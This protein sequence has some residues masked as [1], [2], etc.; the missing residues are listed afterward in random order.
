MNLPAKH[1][2]QD[3]PSKSTNLCVVF[4]ADNNEFHLCAA[5]IN[6]PVRRNGVYI[7]DNGIHEFHVLKG[8]NKILLE[9]MALAGGSTSYDPFRDYMSTDCTP[10]DAVGAGIGVNSMMEIIYFTPDNRIFSFTTP[11]RDPK[12][13]LRI[14]N[15]YP[16][17][18]L[19]LKYKGA[20]FLKTT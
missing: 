6:N 10:K 18:I 14:K 17:F 8:T 7:Y 11:C 5:Q 9:Q 3:L 13:W 1:P 4:C 19:K 12:T 15:I 16:E 20:L 2:N